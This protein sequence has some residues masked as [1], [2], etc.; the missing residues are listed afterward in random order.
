MN[1]ITALLF[2]WLD[3]FMVTSLH[4]SVLW[5]S[6]TS[7]RALGR[8]YSREAST[9]TLLTFNLAWFSAQPRRCRD[10]AHSPQCSRCRCKLTICLEVNR[11]PSLRVSK[12]IYCVHSHPAPPRL[13]PSRVLLQ[14][15]HIG[16]TSNINDP[17]VLGHPTAPALLA[18]SLIFAL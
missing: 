4:L 6:S 15:P 5:S 14:F 8:C 17:S 1:S 13:R 2:P 10:M 7:P 9:W 3:Q 18:P 12:R 11:A 16:C